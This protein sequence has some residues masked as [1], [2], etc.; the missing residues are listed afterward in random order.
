MFDE[1]MENFKKD[2]ANFETTCRLFSDRFKA[3]LEV[4]RSNVTVTTICSLDD[5]PALDG[6]L[7]RLA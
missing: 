7:V 6:S 2:V 5:M 1:E 4:V 3:A